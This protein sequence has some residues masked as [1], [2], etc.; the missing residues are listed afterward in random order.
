MPRCWWLLASLTSVLLIPVNSVRAAD[1]E[2]DDDS[3]PGLVAE[4]SVDSKQVRRID[5]DL[6]FAWGA[7]APDA[8]LPAGPFRA[9][10]AGQLLVR[11]EGELQFHAWLQGKLTVRVRDEVVL[12]AESAT[13]EWVSGPKLPFRFG[14]WPIVVDY[15]RAG[16]QGTLQ[17][18]W[19]SDDFPLEPLPANALYHT[20]A[21]AD[22]K[23]IA[24][25]RLSLKAS[26]ARPAMIGPPMRPSCL[27]RSWTC[28][29]RG[30]IPPG[31]SS[32]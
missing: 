15:E 18:A 4:L 3:R 12:Q 31:W 24:R 30:R 21:D 16:G 9:R 7:D 27:R 1:D 10:W 32:T 5:P 17:V 29:R 11:S 28:F 19:S 25:G 13:A 23:A 14:E 22:L 6:S 26:A 20:A 8:R 2:E